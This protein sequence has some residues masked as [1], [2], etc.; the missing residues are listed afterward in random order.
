MR[1]TF[2]SAFFICSHPFNSFAS[3]VRISSS[4][5]S[6]F[7]ILSR[8]FFGWL[9]FL[10]IA[11]SK[12]S[13]FPFGMNGSS[14]KCIYL[15]CRRYRGRRRRRS[16]FA[17]FTGDFRFVMALCVSMRDNI[18]VFESLNEFLEMKY[19]HFIMNCWRSS[20][21]L[22]MTPKFVSSWTLTWWR[23][24][25]SANKKWSEFLH[26]FEALGSVHIG[27]HLGSI[28]I[29]LSAESASA[30]RYRFSFRTETVRFILWPSYLDWFSFIFLRFF[31]LC[32]EWI[33]HKVLFK[34]T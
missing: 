16:C 28:I 22:F 3:I 24:H 9:L 15:C 19:T 18:Q 33:W 11:Q 25:V 12:R 5:S 13:F 10:F 6:Y 2:I 21:G 8:I 32:D 4:S 29:N 7:L 17:S 34:N 30:R 23:R 20:N 14:W 31:A 27:N 1:Y 26:Q